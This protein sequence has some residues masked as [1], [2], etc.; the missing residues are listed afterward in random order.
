M[1]EINLN[2]GNCRYGSEW[3]GLESGLA[4]L[5]QQLNKAQGKMTD[6]FV[7]LQEAGNVPVEDVAERAR[8]DQEVTR[9][10]EITFG[11]SAD[12]IS[13]LSMIDNTFKKAGDINCS[14]QE[15]YPASCPRLGRVMLAFPPIASEAAKT[16]SHWQQKG[17]QL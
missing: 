16:V 5:I 3:A 11:E 6:S 8:R 4:P 17:G 12:V 14:A 1:T 2:C 7:E 9:A 10:E 13:L 15:D